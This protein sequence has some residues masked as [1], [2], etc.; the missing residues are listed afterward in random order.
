ML[1]SA[2]ALRVLVIVTF[3]IFQK[4]KNYYKKEKFV[5]TLDTIDRCR[6]IKILNRAR[7]RRRRQEGLQKVTEGKRIDSSPQQHVIDC[8]FVCF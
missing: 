5:D 1:A 6:Y 7:R 2:S 3:E 4:N 8:F